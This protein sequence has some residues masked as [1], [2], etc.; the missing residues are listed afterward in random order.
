MESK[1]DASDMLSVNTL[2]IIIVI[3]AV[4]VAVCCYW[5][6]NKTSVLQE[7]VTVLTERVNKYEDIMKNQSELIAKH[8][9]ALQQIFAVMNRNQIVQQ[10]QRQQ[11]PMKKPPPP[12]K[13]ESRVEEIDENEAD[14]IIADEL[15]EL[16]PSKDEECEDGVCNVAPKG[17]KKTK[18]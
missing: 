16:N 6:Y 13:Q 18:K 14:D 8:E 7:Q 5:I 4:I 1:K 15:E 10:P 2:I 9:N 11:Q 17:K 3:A 12:K